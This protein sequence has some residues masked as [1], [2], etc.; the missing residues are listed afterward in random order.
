MSKKPKSSATEKPPSWRDVITIHPAANL[1]P[2]MSAEALRELADDIKKQKGLTDSVAMWAPGDQTEGHEFQLLDG[3]N[4]LDAMELLGLPTIEQNSKTKKWEIKDLLCGNSH[5]L[6]MRSGSPVIYLYEFLK[7]E[8]LDG[9]G[10]EHREPSTDP[11][12][13]VLSVNKH[14]RHLDNAG[15][16][17]WIAVELKRD[18]SRSDVVIAKHVGASDK[19]VATVRAEMEATSEIP[20]L[21]ARTG[22]DGRKRTPPKAGKREGTGKDDKGKNDKGKDDKPDNP[23]DTGAQAGAGDDARAKG[24]VQANS[25]GNAQPLP[26]QQPKPAT[27]T[28]TDTVRRLIVDLAAFGSK[29]IDHKKLAIAL[30]GAILDKALDV[31]RQIKTHHVEAGAAA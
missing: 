10:K 28:D 14:R 12:E 3:R 19:T 24:A 21:N 25:N 2:L 13:Y 6:G 4:R 9:S 18:P 15:R 23:E 29:K 11:Y 27:D 17:E 8:P 5:L 16:R 22:K 30:D 26:K 31:L 7:S 20:K 1:F